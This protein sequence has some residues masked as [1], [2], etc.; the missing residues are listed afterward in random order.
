MARMASQ[1]FGDSTVLAYPTLA[2]LLFV[3]VFVGAA[4]VTVRRGRAH[5]DRMAALPL[6]GDRS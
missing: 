6:E 3:A 1:F 5:A 4:V 2:L